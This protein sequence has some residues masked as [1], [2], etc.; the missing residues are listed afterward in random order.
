C[1]LD[2]EW[3]KRDEVPKMTKLVIIKVTMNGADVEKKE[4]IEHAFQLATEYCSV[5]QTLSKVAEM[6]YEVAFE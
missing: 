6:K 3:E 4:R 1:R 2:I 5:F